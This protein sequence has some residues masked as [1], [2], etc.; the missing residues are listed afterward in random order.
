MHHHM[1]E[2]KS[3]IFGHALFHFTICTQAWSSFQAT[4]IKKPKTGTTEHC[5][6]ETASTTS[7]SNTFYEDDFSSSDDSSAD[8]G[9]FVAILRMEYFCILTKHSSLPNKIPFHSQTMIQSPFLDSG[10]KKL[11]L[12]R[13]QWLLLPRY[14]SHH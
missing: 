13:N 14:R 7:D 3:V 12:Q 10:L 11:C 8:D 2:N 6:S 1:E 4:S 9:M 5:G